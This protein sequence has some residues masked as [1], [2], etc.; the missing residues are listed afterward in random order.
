ML[1]SLSCV[2]GCARR[3]ARKR[4]ARFPH[5][6][7]NRAIILKRIN[8]LERP[9]PPTKLNTWK[10]ATYHW[11]RFARTSLTIGKEATIVTFP[12][13]VEYLFAEGLIDYVLIGI[14][15]ASWHKNAVIVHTEAIVRPEGIIKC[16]RALITRIWVDKN[17]GWTILHKN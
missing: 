9:R 16:E 6:H 2:V 12:G 10:S 15:G 13:V 3:F 4:W 14:F 7:R 11:I 1:W 5:W 17:C 8:L